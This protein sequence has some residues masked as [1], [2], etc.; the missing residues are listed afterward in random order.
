MK[1][2]QEGNANGDLRGA[3]RDPETRTGRESA[4]GTGPESGRSGGPA[5]APPPGSESVPSPRP[6]PSPVR[7]VPGAWPVVGHAPS[8]M[9]SPLDFVTSLAAHGDVVRLR[10][11]PLPIHAITHPELVQRVLVDDAR[12]FERGRLFE[13]AALFFGGGVGTVSGAAHVKQRRILQPAFQRG[14]VADYTPL[15]REAVEEAVTSWRPGRVLSVTDV[16]NDLSFAMLTST[17]FTVGFTREASAAVQRSVPVL[18]RGAMVRTILPEWWT[19]LPTPGN[20]RFARA[21][22]EMGRAV[23]G[24]IAAYRAAGKD[25]GDLLSMLLALRDEDG[26]GLTD[27]QVHDQVINFAIAGIE[28]TGAT[29]AWFFHEL[30]R[31]PAAEARVHEELDAV[32]GGRPPRH[33]DL[34]ALKYTG[35]VVMEVLRLYAVW[36]FTRRALTPVRLGNTVIPAGGEVLYSPYA[37]HHDPRWFPAPDAFDPD[38]WL[39]ERSADVP[40][41]AFIPFGAGAHQCMGNTYAFME[42][43][44]AV[45]VICQRWRLCPIPGTR[46]RKTATV[47]VHPD[48]LPMTTEPRGGEGGGGAG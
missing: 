18:L 39:P 20:R 16:M 37:L 15:V 17:L 38:R 26:T 27:R 13:K 7:S 35:R 24:A 1:K 31:N 40:K 41:G 46:I 4:R 23:D 2:C 29:L 12:H 48:H 43:L 6:V 9:R 30:G 25:H 21:I 28:T 44:V 11:G 3:G 19:G 33:E 22:D 45:A 36:M 32:L 47:D 8:L 42:A 34:P 10:L 5:G 14:K